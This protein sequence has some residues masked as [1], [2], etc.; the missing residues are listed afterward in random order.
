ML[1][2]CQIL[3]NFCCKIVLHRCDSQKCRRFFT[4]C[5]LRN[6]ALGMLG[7]GP[8]SNTCPPSTDLQYRALASCSHCTFIHCY[9]CHHSCCY[10]IFVRNLWLKYVIFVATWPQGF[11]FLRAMFVPS[12][13]Y[14]MFVCLCVCVFVCLF[15]CVCVHVRML[16][17]YQHQTN[18]KENLA[19]PHF[20]YRRQNCSQKKV[21]SL[22]NCLLF[23]SCPM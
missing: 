16:S 3:T 17:A 23:S 21:T 8:T 19:Y 5:F 15:V 14:T 13:C 10:L 4:S 2:A 7:S 22:L 18:R 6:L 1:D 12:D 20:T 9:R 11:T